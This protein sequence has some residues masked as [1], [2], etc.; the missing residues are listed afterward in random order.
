MSEKALRQQIEEGFEGD[1]EEQERIKQALRS[2][3]VQSGWRDEIKTRIT[4][5]IAARGL[6]NVTVEQIIE[7]VLPYAKESVSD[8]VKAALVAMLR[9]SLQNHV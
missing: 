5:F 4:E 6:D 1:E 3:L 7:D 9:E 8:D 2:K